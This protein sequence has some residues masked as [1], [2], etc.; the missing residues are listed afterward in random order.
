MEGLNAK[1]PLDESNTET[2]ELLMKE[3]PKYQYGNG[4]LSDGIIGAWMAKMCGIGEILDTDKVKS[5]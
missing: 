5:I 4:C 2:Q 3:G 1:L